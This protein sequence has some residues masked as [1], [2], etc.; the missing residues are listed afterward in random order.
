MWYQ[1][2]AY[3]KFILNSSNQHGIH[4]PFVYDLVTNCIYNKKKYNP[5]KSLNQYR[6]KL[7]ANDTKILVKDYGA[8]SR[9]TKNNNRKISRIAKT[10]GIT[11][12]RALLLYRLTNYF[13]PSSIL[14]LGT[15]LGLATS[16]LSLGNPNSKI[17]TI[18]GCPKTALIT[19]KHFET[20]NLKNIDLRINNFKDEIESFKNNRF[21][22]IYIDG[23]HQKNATLNYFNTLLKFISNNSIIIFDDINWS[24]GMSEAWKQIKNNPKV[25]I[26]V[27]TFY[28]GIVFFKQGQAKQHFKI[29]V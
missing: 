8:G 25:T 21:D 26:T 9:V 3:I 15:S 12:K 4:S 19:K 1:V 24:S 2:L 10:A 22:L 27:D 20:F 23:H 29:R 6:M 7:Y 13:Q 14:E 18:E 28:W 11:K 5:Y 17:I 16:A